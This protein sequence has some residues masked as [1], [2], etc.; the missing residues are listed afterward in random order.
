MMGTGK[1][2]VNQEIDMESAA[3]RFSACAVMSAV[4]SSGVRAADTGLAA[5]AKPF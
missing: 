2:P 3:Y 1:F 4:V 5:Q